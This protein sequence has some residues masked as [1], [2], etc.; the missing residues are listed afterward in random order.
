MATLVWR[1]RMASFSG[2]DQSS[3]Q[4]GAPRS[5][6]R[7]PIR[8]GAECE[9]VRIPRQYRRRKFFYFRRARSPRPTT[10]PDC[11]RWAHFVSR[12]AGDLSR[13]RGRRIAW[14]SLSPSAVRAQVFNGDGATQRLGRGP[15]GKR[16][17][18]AAAGSWST[19]TTV[20]AGAS[21]LAPI[22]RREHHPARSPTELR[23]GLD[24]T[25]SRDSPA[26]NPRLLRCEAVGQI[27]YQTTVTGPKRAPSCQM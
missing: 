23:G 14:S 2:Q 26:M 16:L 1:E 24:R 17:R 12:Y 11:G 5:F 4:S 6:Q 13:P 9:S 25:A 3:T 19:P 27:S 21:L 15:E 18:K 20:G 10:L 8:G 7:S 22:S